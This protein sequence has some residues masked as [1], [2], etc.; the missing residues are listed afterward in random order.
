MSAHHGLPGARDPAG[1]LAHALKGWGGH[2][3]VWVFGYASLIWRPEFEAA[4][5]RP[6]TAYGWHRALEMRSRVNRGTPECP[7]LVFA[8]VK[9][10]SCRGIVY[11]IEEKHARA[12]LERLWER[13][14]PTGIYDPKWLN[15]RTPQGSVKALAFTL[16]RQ[17]PSHT[18]PLP[19]AQM[20]DILRHANGRFGSTLSY[21]VETATSLRSCGIR[22]RDIERLVSLAR[23]HD[24]TA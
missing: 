12:Q 1:L 7:G 16:S 20:I 24:L 11:R 9:G 14:M 18:G 22:D 15:C 3:D 8:L 10:G 2:G 6:A 5:E 4:E 21:L 23:R 19:D 17:S 13:E